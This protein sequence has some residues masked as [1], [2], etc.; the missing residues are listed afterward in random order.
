MR[1]TIAAL[2]PDDW[3][4]ENLAEEFVPSGGLGLGVGGCVHLS[5]RTASDCLDPAEQIKER[6]RPG[7][8]CHQREVEVGIGTL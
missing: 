1:G 6:Q 5:T 2:Q 8:A 4:A 7:I 3:S